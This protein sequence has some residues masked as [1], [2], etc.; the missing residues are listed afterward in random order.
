MSEKLHIIHLEDNPVDAELIQSTLEEEWSD[1]IVEQVDTEPAFINA[2][3]HSSCGLILADFSLPLY[4][5]M[6]ALAEVRKRCPEIPFIIVSGTLGEEKAIDSIKSGA[7][8]YVLKHRLSRLVPAVQRAL[9]EAQEL[10]KRSH[11]EQELAAER[12]LLR[13]LINTIP[14]LVWLKD[15]EGVYL[16][17]NSEFERLFGAREA[18]ILGKTDY[19]Y[20]DRELADFFRENDRKAMAVDAPSANEE[21][22]VYASD[23]HRALFE[24]IKTPM[25]DSKRQLM[26]VLGVGRDIT[27]IKQAEKALRESEELYRSLFENMLNGFAYCRMIFEGDTPQDF[28]YLSVNEAFEKQT[29]L[30]DVVGRRVTEVI[31]GIC[32]RDPG[33]FEVY[34][35]VAMT[36]KPEQFETY[37]EALEQWY[38]IS[39]YSP[40]R[41]Y[42]VAV[43]DVITERRS[44]EEQL[45][46]S[47]KM[48]AVGTL[49][50]GIAHDFNNILT[51][52]IGYST[53]LQMDLYT[54]DKQRGYVDNLTGL[55]ERAA[56]LT[57]GLLAFSRN[58]V[59][60]LRLIS[61]ND[62]V[63]TITKLI[64]RLIG[65]N[66]VVETDLST[67]PLTIMADCGQ[68]EQV[69]MNLATNARDAMSDGGKL[70]IST[71]QI[72]LDADSL[73]LG[74]NCP[75]GPYALLSVSDTGN[76]METATVAR[77]FEPFFTTKELGK[78]TG[79]GLSILYGIIKQHHGCVTVDSSPGFGTTFTIYLPLAVP[80][81]VP[82][83]G[84]ASVPLTGGTETVLL[85]EDDPAIRKV[86]TYI[87]QQFGYVVLEAAD[88]EEA[89]E[90]FSAN[91]A[92]IS[93][94][95]L[96]AIMPR[97][98]AKEVFKRIVDIQPE[99]KAL[100]ISGYPSDIIEQRD[101]LPEGA[102][103]LPKPVSPM[104]LLR[105]IRQILD[106]QR[107]GGT[108]E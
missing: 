59:M 11:A 18:D 25:Y 70:L 5:G 21:W 42:F 93:L 49:A 47:Q 57:K 65:E 48:E 61:L 96:D 76:G 82:V 7:T 84:K 17:C 36:G 74:D 32:E 46:Q 63:I 56:N 92:Q 22:L 69:L 104:E 4:D 10:R 20:V 86:I 1:C 75:P 31:P 6:S 34:G 28:I 14:D 30:K 71:D 13:T 62:I 95:I 79:L 94:V 77:I 55:V 80:V 103:F 15:S 60:T 100:F 44:L 50:G 72:N 8:D 90:V 16:A 26:G 105:S 108:H 9:K 12:T 78:G 68:I 106:G 33:L 73:L 35:R 41:E 91:A 19:D 54:N 40:A 39:V 97:K 64:S 3:E 45:R 2:L 67:C 66:I 37:V 51:A 85:A 23:G 58:Q 87:L 107:A 53:L 29:G 98:N 81:D 89:I 88:G 24:T 99:I 38:W 83:N 43:F 102:L 101:L 52:I 27:G